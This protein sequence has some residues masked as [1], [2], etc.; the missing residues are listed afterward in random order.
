VKHVKKLFLL[1]LV[2]LSL[3]LW[4]GG[5]SSD[6]HTHGAPVGLPESQSIAPRAAT[7]TEEFEVVASLEGKKLVVYVDRFGSNEP[8]AQAKVEI[9][10][11]GLK[12]VA[13]ET[14]PGT[15][16][17]D[18]AAPLL[19]AKHPLTLSIEA[20]ESVDLLSATL[21]TSASEVS[22]V[23]AHGWSEWVVWGVSGAL[24]VLTGILFVVR[25]R[26]GLPG[27]AKKGI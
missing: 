15:Y 22:V 5:D 4:A 2:A 10:G 23:H 1:T 12:G 25:R 18:L 27:R 6:G 16:V 11:A 21:D 20:G 24:L 14:A 26:S 8:V 7:A 3:P 17:L 13:S 9:E 19:P